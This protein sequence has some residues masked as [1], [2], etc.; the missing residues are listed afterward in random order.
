MKRL[1][2]SF[3]DKHAW[4]AKWH[5]RANHAL[6]QWLFLFVVVA[7]VAFLFY[8]KSH[9]PRE[10]Q[11]L[12]GLQSKADN[13]F[14]QA[15]HL[16][17]TLP[18]ITGQ[19]L[20]KA[21]EFRKASAEARGTTLTELTNL[22][23][24]RKGLLVQALKDNPGA[25]IRNTI[26]TG[27]RNHLPPEIQKLVEQNVNLNGT[28]D[29]VHSDDFDNDISHHQ[30]TLKSKAGD[31]EIYFTNNPEIPI[32]FSKAKLK[33]VQ[34]DNKVVVDNNLSGNL[35]IT[36]DTSLP[37]LA[38]ASTQT[39]T[40][41]LLIN[42]SDGPTQPWTIEQIRDAVF[43]GTGSVNKYYQE[44]SF[45]QQE[46]VGKLRPDGDI[47]G[48]ITVPHN[49][50]TCDYRDFTYK[51]EQLAVAQGNDLSGYD[52]IIHIW[53]S[54]SCGFSGIVYGS[55]T[56]QSGASGINGSIGLYVMGHELG[57]AFQA[58]HGQTWDCRENGVRVSIS[59]TCA[60]VD[61]Y[62]DPFTIMGRSTHHHTISEKSFDTGPTTYG[63]TKKP[64]WLQ[65][66]NTLTLSSGD[67]TYMLAPLEQSTGGFQQIKVGPV[68][69]SG[70]TS[71]YAQYYNLEFRQPYGF[72]NFS[73]SDPVI[74]GVT[75]RLGET[76]NSD[77]RIIDT[78]PATS[79]FADAPLAVGKAFTDSAYGISITTLSVSPAGAQVRISFGGAPPCSQLAPTASVTPT[80]Q[81]GIAGG[82]LSYS[83]TMTNMDTTA[84]PPSTYTITPNLPAGW[85][86]TPASF[87][88]ILPPGATVTRYFNVTSVDTA[89]GSNSITLNAT[90]T[91]NASLTRS[92]SF[93]YDI[94]TI[95]NTPPTVSM[96][97]P[98]DGSTVSGT[99]V[100]V[101]ASA[102]D[103][104][105]IASVQFKL[106]GSNLG[107]TVTAGVNGV[108]SYSWNTSGI[109]NG[110]H[111][112]TATAT[113]NASPANSATS[114]GRIVTV[115]NTTG[116][117]DITPPA[118]T[119]SVPSTV[120]TKG[121][122][123][124]NTTATDT[125]GVSSIIITF[126]GVTIATCYSKTSC[127][128]SKSVT[129]IS[130]GS[131]T[132]T[133]TARDKSINQNSATKTATVVK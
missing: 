124:I 35:D 133:V 55:Y 6:I 93:T 7:G 59:N 107:S 104:S 121:Q 115:Q 18:S 74:N 40:A 102:T 70:S 96:A 28:L 3:M 9:T 76:I 29:H 13:N 125:S 1:H 86:M 111:T 4:Y 110:T 57:H 14:D 103:A 106:D 54:L 19:M 66:P 97:A 61:E 23:E 27:L 36:I 92:A 105:G 114:L 130:A 65:P 58:F 47:I 122:L 37:L 82:T 25:I 84:C 22:A 38:T 83:V 126:D 17:S 79:S 128:G 21:H 46:L 68:Y 44:N 60:L 30:Y 43:T 11:A 8:Q 12:T 100:T 87:T 16:E 118:I 24:Q 119:I 109:S 20:N 33:G 112:I 81:S 45:G 31:K 94:P 67:G 80:N 123:K 132:I 117:E 51:A 129:A 116:V 69:R 48:Y 71:N 88:E 90:N 77:S 26:P 10:E 42:F 99:S 49:L 2:Q 98:A 52:H 15:D 85:A 75:I 120:P 64:N 89:L 32:G 50:T 95:E 101:S 41:V 39:K 72:D 5:N 62:G 63:T 91:A 56:T 34:L 127:V 108:Y 131:H 53:P 73:S 78:T 113:D